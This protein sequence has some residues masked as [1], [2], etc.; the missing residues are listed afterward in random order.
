MSQSPYVFAGKCRNCEWT[1]DAY[2]DREGVIRF[3]LSSVGP[4]NED[5]GKCFDCRYWSSIETVAVFAP[6][7]VELVSCDRCGGHGH[8]HPNRVEAGRRITAAGG[9]RRERRRGFRS[10]SDL[11][12]D[13]CPKCAGS[14]TMTREALRPTSGEATQP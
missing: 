7:T 13:T 11:L 12:T 14:G 3:G 9:P 10:T 5:P 2:V 8:V 4:A 6:A 1:R